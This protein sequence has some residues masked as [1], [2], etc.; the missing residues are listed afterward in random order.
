MAAREAA[1]VP[2]ALDRLGAGP[3]VILIAGALQGRATYRPLAEALS[4]HVTVVNYD[5]RGRG[6]SG[7]GRPYTVE[8]ELEDLAP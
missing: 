1:E 6:D 3:P 7:D 2:L 5:R 4:R 8:R